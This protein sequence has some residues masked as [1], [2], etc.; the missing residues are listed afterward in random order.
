[1]MMDGLL[2]LLLL[3]RELMTWF[4]GVYQLRQETAGD[5]AGNGV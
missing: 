4:I 1:M 5:C 2:I 3:T